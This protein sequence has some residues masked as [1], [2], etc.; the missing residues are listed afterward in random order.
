MIEERARKIKLLVLDVD[1]VLTGG[2]VFYGNFGNE[3][4]AFNVSDGLG[5]FLLNKTDIKSVII[6]AR[7]SGIVRYRAKDMYVTKVYTGHR[8]LKIY[9]TLLNRFKVK[10]DEVCFMGDD[11]LDLPI[12]KKVGFSVAPPNAVEDVKNSA[13]YIT[14]KQGGK[15]AVRELIEI[16]LKSQGLWDRVSSEYLK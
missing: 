12:I 11:L 10:D 7:K 9:N 4:K 5:M 1:G 2:E 16:I 8:K 14:K 6:T 3:L 15:G 13:H